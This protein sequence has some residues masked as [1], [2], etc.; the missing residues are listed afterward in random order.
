M[1]RG[2]G[3]EWRGGGD[4]GAPSDQIRSRVEGGSGGGR[5]GG[6]EGLGVAPAVRC[7]G[8]V[9]MAQEVTDRRDG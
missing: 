5:S 2:R 7:K 1:E 6:R 4:A 9:P 3:R 8:R